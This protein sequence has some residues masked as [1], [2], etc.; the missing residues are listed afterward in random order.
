MSMR[1][2]QKRRTFNMQRERDVAE[3]GYYIFMSQLS[4]ECGNVERSTKFAQ[5][6][7]TRAQQLANYAFNVYHHL[8]NEAI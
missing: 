8:R 6:A 4:L 3:I 1:G 7:G 5:A 2:K